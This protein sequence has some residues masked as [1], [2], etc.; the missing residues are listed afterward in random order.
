[1][2]VN[3]KVIWVNYDGKEDTTGDNKILQP[4]NSYSI[5]TYT[6]HPW[7]FREVK[8]GKRLGALFQ[9]VSSTVFEGDKFN[10]KPNQKVVVV[11]L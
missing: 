11:N 10:I 1:M 7:I 3:V 2:T 6:T 9:G 5:N 4:R 8:S